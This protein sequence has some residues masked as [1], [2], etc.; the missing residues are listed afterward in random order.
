MYSL[1]I[2]TTIVQAGMYATELR[3]KVQVASRTQVIEDYGA[4]GAISRGF[5]KNFVTMLTPGGGGGD[6]QQV[7]DLIAHLV[8]LPA[9]QRPLYQ[10][11]GPQSEGLKGLNE[12]HLGIQSH[13]IS[14]L[15]LDS[16]LKRG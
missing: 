13:V 6:P 7:A 3:E 12:A 10:E 1:G 15:G 14:G 5:S 2:D 4:I 16:L 11:V 9:G 8:G